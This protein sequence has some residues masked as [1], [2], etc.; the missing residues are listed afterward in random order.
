MS[1]VARFLADVGDPSR[2]AIGE[3]VVVVVAHP[4]D[5][6]LGCGALL[7][8][9]RDLRLVHV[10]DGAPPDGADAE[11]C[12]YASP[13]DYAEARRG[14]LAAAMALAGVPADRRA[15]LDTPDQAAAYKM[16]GITGRLLPL[17]DG[18][19]IVLTHAF[20]GGHPDHDATAFAVHAA[21]RLL[22]PGRGPAIVEMPFY[23]AD[24]AGD[25]GMV[26]SSFAA[27]EGVTVLCL[28][29]AERRLKAAMLAAHASQAET[30]GPFG[31]ADEAF[32]PAQE[33][34]FLARPNGGLVLYDS[35]GWQLDGDDFRDW[36][37]IA[38]VELGFDRPA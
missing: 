16:A 3:R 30:L 38:R 12:G 20:E 17:L 4:D 35:F 36:A 22:G 37:R 2:P 15:G 19:A 28:G 32:R 29:D 1:A 34:D 13:A 10:T 26:R 5:E 24:L 21:S 8:R 9:L 6:T 7:P 18:A 11:R 33:I 31:V 23:R 25:H 27:P 14:E